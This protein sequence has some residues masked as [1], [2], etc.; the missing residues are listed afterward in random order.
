VLIVLHVVGIYKC[1]FTGNSSNM[2]SLCK[3]HFFLLCCLL[4]CFKAVEAQNEILHSVRL[5]LDENAMMFKEKLYLHTDKDFYTAG[6]IMWFKIYALDVFTNKPI[7]E[8]K[9]AYLELLDINNSPVSRVK[10]EMNL[11]GGSGS[12]QLPITVNSGYYTIRVYTNWMKN[13]GPALFFHKKIG[14]INTLKNLDNQAPASSNLYRLTLY[15]EGGNLVEGLT[16][17]VAYH[18]SDRLGKGVKGKGF[19]VDEN[20]DT[21][22]I[23]SPYKFGMGTFDLVPRKGVHYKVG[24]VTDQGTLITQDLPKAY[25]SGYVM[26]VEEV[27][28]GL[29]ATV[30]TNI[31][32]G[33]PEVYLMCQ[34]KQVVKWS[35]R[36]V[37]E[38]GITSFYISKSD[39]AEG[40]N[41]FTLFNNQQLP[42]CER[43]YFVQPT[44]RHSLLVRSDLK[45]YGRRKPVFLSVDSLRNLKT[46]LSLSV[47]QLDAYSTDL[48]EN[49]VEYSWL[50]SEL[51]GDI[52]QPSY[53]FSPFNEEVK[54]TT[55]YLMLT[56]GWRRFNW[57]NILN[58]SPGKSFMIE[59]SGQQISA[60]V[61]DPQTNLA[62]KDVQVFLSIPGAT[63]K[64]YT[65]VTNKDG[66]AKFPVQDF[67][68]SSEIVLQ[69]SDRKD[70]IY[71]IE[72]LS[73]FYESYLTQHYP[74]LILN[75]SFKEVLEK[76]SISMQA[77]HVYS[78]DLLKQFALPHQ[79]DTLPFYGTPMYTYRFDDYKRFTTMEE[80]LREYVREISVG[81]K[82][83]GTSLRVKL[84]NEDEKVNYQENIIVLV[85][86]VPLLDP[87]VIFSY[88][89]LKLKGVDVITKNY[90]IGP[91]TYHALANFYS[92]TGTFE[93][94]EPARS[95]VT[96]DYEGLQLQRRF[97]SPEYAT[98]PA[99]QSRI[100][101]LRTTLYWSPDVSSKTISFYTGDNKGNYLVVIQG[102]DENGEPLNAITQFTVR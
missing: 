44:S 99:V 70:S 19:L 18:I 95:A 42:V 102:I 21:L 5:K 62:V 85:D 86:G 68:G 73:P 63:Y 6:E 74:P 26:S 54:R 59:H 23:F 36:A 81:V 30:T 32:S 82:G 88:D 91:S 3:S 79:Q 46:N 16:S 22:S 34:A 83:T 84:L 25:E 40:I 41:Q 45:E 52:E 31:R 100:P 27:P 39:L 38:N 94:F 28:T 37:L 48:T 90:V 97:Y 51:K 58:A 72:V 33:Y 8:S 61:T 14:I 49:I 78:P 76:N 71:K 77:E 7:N 98:E 55:D 47:Y 10:V 17:R 75:S 93:G 24:F 50:T 57:E 89:P 1:P 12:V 92:Y 101:D 35:Q 65:A 2:K 4:F 11:K 56:H 60:R 64:L 80:V 20:N 13:D 9:L 53:Y 66:I 96:I 87:N 69:P 67:Y 15:P 29:K 43:L